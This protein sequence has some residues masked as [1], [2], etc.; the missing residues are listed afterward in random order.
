MATPLIN[1]INYDWGSVNLILFGVPVVGITKISYKSAQAKE[2]NYGQGRK[3]VS[4]G[5]GAVT[6][7]ASIEMYLDEWKKI[8]ALAP[9]KDPLQ[10]P[11]FDIS[12]LF[13]GAGV[14]PK[15][16]TL[17]SAEFLEN[18]MDANQGDTKLMVT[19]PL[20][21]ADIEHE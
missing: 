18:P 6:Y 13:G 15:K 19:I 9:N 12:V 8:I 3:P 5:Y 2:N 16:D 11:A 14:L 17:R 10:I 4:R 7:E 20:I 21:I 1:G